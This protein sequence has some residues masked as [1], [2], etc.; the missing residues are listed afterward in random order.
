MGGYGPKMGL[1]ILVNIYR[2]VPQPDDEVGGAVQI[3][4]A[5]V[6]GI[7]ARINQP[8][9]PLQFRLQGIENSEMFD[10]SVSSVEYTEVDVQT[11]DILVPQSGQFANVQF[12]VRAVQAPSSDDWT[13]AYRMGFHKAISIERLQ[14]RLNVVLN[15]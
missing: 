7:P 12:R 1:N 11:D 15:G 6:K 13:I 8:K 3:A 2:R 14:P 9:T 10:C 5:T 4:T